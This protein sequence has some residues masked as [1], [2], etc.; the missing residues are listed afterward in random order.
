[1]E[2]P[3]ALII[4]NRPHTTRKVIDRIHKARPSQ[5]FVIADG[6]RHNR[7]DDIQL[8]TSTRD[9]IDQVDWQCEVYK[10]YADEN[11]GP[12]KRIYTGLNWVF[13]QVDKCLILE[14]DV[15]P[16][17]DFFPFCDELLLRYANDKRIMLIS[18]FGPSVKNI[19]QPYSYF[20][21]R[22]FIPLG[23]ATWKRA[24]DNFDIEMKIWNELRETD[25]LVEILGDRLWAKIVHDRF[26]Q[27]YNAHDKAVD[28]E[29]AFY[30]LSQSGYAIRPYG[31]L[32]EYISSI[33]DATHQDFAKAIEQHIKIPTS[34][35]SFPI[36]HPPHMVRD[37]D[38]DLSLVLPIWKA[39][40]KYY[41]RLSYKRKLRR[42]I[43]QQIRNL[44]P[45]SIRNYIKG[46]F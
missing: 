12:G 17:K 6:P 21:S 10:H 39:E 7:P 45:K 34:S 32:L 20:F 22:S 31:N 41:R 5:L 46:L 24:W 28:V 15:L 40:T 38:S 1:M 42:I 43:T 35:M 25:W 44:I 33:G 37:K 14:D 8:C 23:W 30:C 11:L 19:S 2:T 4:F 3:V 16:H 27:R 26:E 18:G 13:Q 9:T 29:W 36:K